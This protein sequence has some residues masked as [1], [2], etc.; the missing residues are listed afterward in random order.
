MIQ[1]I[2]ALGISYAAV[3]LYRAFCA[4]TGFSGIPVVSGS[5][6][7]GRFEAER[8]TA[9]PHGKR[10][11]V[12]FNADTSTSLPWKFTPQQKFV[13]LLPGETSLAFY[14]AKNLSDKDVIGI[15]TY[16]VT[17]SKVGSPRF[18]NIGLLIDHPP[19]GRALLRQDRMFLLRGAEATG[20]RGN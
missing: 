20:G 11:K 4:T 13:T 16:N 18:Q 1:F 2:T 14:T 9:L 10:I 3:P 8:L 6:P 19:I 5:A 12:N 17:P 15:A 7:D